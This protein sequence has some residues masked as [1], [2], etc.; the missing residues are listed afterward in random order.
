MLL[1][2]E[3]GISPKNLVI[4]GGTRFAGHVSQFRSVRHAKRAL[5]VLCDRSI[6]KELVLT[7]PA[8]KK[9]DKIKAC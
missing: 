7:G 3:L 1:F 5:L 8:M 9:V 2:Q 6:A 4:P